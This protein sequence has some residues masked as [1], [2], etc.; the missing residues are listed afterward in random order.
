MERN[1]LK[2]GKIMT[3]TITKR[4]PDDKY[5]DTYNEDYD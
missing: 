4:E 2:K 5:P 3:F 1:I